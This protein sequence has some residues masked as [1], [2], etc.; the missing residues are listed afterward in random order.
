M[1]KPFSCVLAGDHDH[2]Q[3]AGASGKNN[4]YAQFELSGPQVCQ[5][6]SKCSKLNQFGVSKLEASQS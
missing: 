5:K 1:S 3:V 6:I 4:R 2:T